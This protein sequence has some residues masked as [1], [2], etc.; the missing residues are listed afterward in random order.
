MKTFLTA[1]I[2]CF[3]FFAFTCTSFG[4][5]KSTGISKPGDKTKTTKATEEKKDPK[6]ATK[7]KKVEQKEQQKIK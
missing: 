1:I 6:D 4:M 2:V 5:M 7:G 3:L